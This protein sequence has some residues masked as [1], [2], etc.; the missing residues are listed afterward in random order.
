MSDFPCKC[1]VW[2]YTWAD[3]SMVSVVTEKNRDRV[4]THD[5]AFFLSQGDRK[6]TGYCVDIKVLGRFRAVSYNDMMQKYHDLMGYGK[7]I[8]VDDIGEEDAS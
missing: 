6:K 2:K 3:T 5:F 7:Y 1:E 8:P 4:L